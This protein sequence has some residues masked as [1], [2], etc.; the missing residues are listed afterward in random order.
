MLYLKS[1][2]QLKNHHFFVDKYQR[3]YKWDV[4]QV[5]DILEDI[6]AFK[7][8]G[9]RFYCLQPVVVKAIEQDNS[10]AYELID[11][12]QRLTTIFIILSALQVKLFDVDYQTRKGSAEFLLRIKENIQHEELEM[13][14]DSEALEKELD[15]MWDKFIVHNLEYDNIDNYHF[16]KAFQIIT[17]WIGTKNQG[18]IEVFKNKL[19]SHTKLIWYLI[20]DHSETSEQV[21]M[22]IN[23]GKIPLTNAELIKALF[24]VNNEYSDIPSAFSLK[25]NEIALDWDKIEYALQNDE[26]WY[27]LTE[28]S[29]SEL[30]TRIE[31][32]FDILQNKPAKSKDP[33]YSYRKYAQQK[34]RNW[35]EVKSLFLLLQDWF[36]DHLLYHLVGYLVSRKI[37]NITNIIGIHKQSTTKQDFEDRVKAL[38]KNHFSKKEKDSDVNIYDIEY[39]HYERNPGAVIDVL[40]LHNIMTYL[41]SDSNYRFPFNHF[42]KEKDWS[43]EHIHAQ[44]SKSLT[45][46]DELNTWVNDTTTLLK[47]V[48]SEDNKDTIN[49]LIT[50]LEKI[51]VSDELKEIPKNTKELFSNM[52]ERVFAFFGDITDEDQ[53]HGIGNLA[54]L[55]RNTN[56]ALNNSTFAIKRQKIL[57]IDKEGGFKKN[58]KAIKTFIPVCTKN[59]FVKYYSTD[60][61]QMY[62]WNEKDREDYQSNIALLLTEFLPSK[63]KT[64]A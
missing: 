49:S 32:L 31:L 8:Q 54:L 20:E 22:N 58:E 63:L 39:L 44:N 29:N 45:K 38:V 47:I 60:I 3:G 27:F 7:P 23:S 2:Q 64:N 13:S 41:K 19:V 43:I 42:K 56:S 5:L 51:K 35:E 12:Q 1:I 18:D 9:K 26:F 57:K 28:E 15:K 36:E 40:L 14:L 55:D 6:D 59:I 11:G 53:T 50:D 61:S 46:P 10:N 37:S 62:F 48:P 17:N 33:F 25:Q 4:R 30:P 52:Q 34:K 16:Y 21:F 24:L